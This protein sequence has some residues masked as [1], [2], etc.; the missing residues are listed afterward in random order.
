MTCSV[1][2]IASADEEGSIAF[3]YSLTGL[4]DEAVT[5]NSFAWTLT[6]VEGNVINSKQDVSETPASETFVLLVGDDLKNDLTSNVR[7][8]TAKGTYNTSLGGVPKLNVPFTEEIRFDICSFLNHYTD[9]A[10][11]ICE[12]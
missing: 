12:C 1:K 3:G 7:V 8:L 11:N 9:G 2:I 4:N 6:D 10:A 5:P